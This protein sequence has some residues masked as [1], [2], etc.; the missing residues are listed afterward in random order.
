MIGSKR[1]KK[2]SLNNKISEYGI[3][4]TYNKVALWKVWYT[5]KKLKRWNIK[6]T[7]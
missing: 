7:I 2:Y 5:I 6:L 3:G 1:N 4:A